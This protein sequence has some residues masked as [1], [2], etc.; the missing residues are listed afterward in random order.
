MKSSLIIAI[1]VF[2]ASLASIGSGVLPII[3]AAAS[4]AWIV[5]VLRRFDRIEVVVEVDR[6]V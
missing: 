6:D 1:V 5:Y 2:V 3:T 4:A